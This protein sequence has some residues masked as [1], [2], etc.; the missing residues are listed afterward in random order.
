MS[1]SVVFR[2]LV[3]LL[4][5]GCGRNS[6][7][8]PDPSFSRDQRHHACFDSWLA[9]GGRRR[10]PKQRRTVPHC[11]EGHGPTLQEGPLVAS[12]VLQRL[13]L[14]L[15]VEEIVLVVQ[16]C[17]SSVIE[18]FAL[19]TSL[20]VVRPALVVGFGVVGPPWENH[21]GGAWVPRV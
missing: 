12:V 18:V 13:V 16:I 11:E 15:I 5:L 10:L 20:V 1:V 21:S 14:P 3:P 17:Q 8:A 9:T 4:S 19:F 7:N 2:F 6:G